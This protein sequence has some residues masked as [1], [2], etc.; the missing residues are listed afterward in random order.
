MRIQIK[1]GQNRVYNRC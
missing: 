1:Y